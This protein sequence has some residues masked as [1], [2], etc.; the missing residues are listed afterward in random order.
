MYSNYNGVFCSV[1]VSS[2]AGRGSSTL[3][4]N[5]SVVKTPLPEP[6][7]V[8]KFSPEIERYLLS[9]EV[10]EL[11]RC[12]PKDPVPAGIPFQDA[13]VQKGL[14]GN[15]SRT[16]SHP[17]SSRTSTGSS[18]SESP[19]T[20]QRSSQDFS[21]RF[22]TTSSIDGHSDS[23]NS[24]TYDTPTNNQPLPFSNSVHVPSHYDVPRHSLSN[25]MSSSGGAQL[26]SNNYM[27]P[28][29][30][31]MSDPLIRYDPHHSVTRPKEGHYDYP[32]WRENPLPLRSDMPLPPRSDLPLPPRSEVPLPPRNIPHPGQ[33]SSSIYD[34]PPHPRPIIYQHSNGI[35]SL[36]QEMLPT[37]L[38]AVTET[39]PRRK[40]G[41]GAEI[42]RQSG[43]SGCSSR[44][45]SI[46]T[47]DCP[48]LQQ[49]NLP[50]PPPS[51]IFRRDSKGMADEMIPNKMYEMV[52][53]AGNKNLEI[54]GGDLPTDRELDE[55]LAEDLEE[56]IKIDSSNDIEEIGAIP[57]VKNRYVNLSM[58]E[59]E[60][61]V[62]PPVDRSLKPYGAPMI[63]LPN[64]PM[65]VDEYDGDTTTTDDDDESSLSQSLP[66]STFRNL[67]QEKPSIVGGGSEEI[68]VPK[69][70]PRLTSHSVHYTQ[71]SFDQRSKKPIPTPRSN[72][73]PNASPQRRVNYSDININTLSSSL[74]ALNMSSSPCHSYSGVDESNESIPSS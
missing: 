26:L 45:Q 18:I 19:I 14:A 65:N 33:S 49:E 56:T 64:K 3:P 47:I 44:R 17:H 20:S 59:E 63:D 72:C 25:A 21:S 6:P 41:T 16:F 10:V 39:S 4:G 68:F 70:I 60:D 42:R 43:G 32:P 48:I 15:H 35:Q 55:D 40:S 67:S 11:L 23:N 38:Q 13:M 71:V 58:M 12:K 30:A 22:S 5:F 62:P 34:V 28:R 1:T 9:P 69:E 27:V 29:Q 8:Q 53:A 7:H 37:P 54:A 24:F 57:V 52:W 36:S 51:I 66:S 74:N 2:A 61:E 50:P 46:D 31:R 73:T